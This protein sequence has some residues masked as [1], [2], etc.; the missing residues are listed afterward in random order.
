MIILFSVFD[1]IYTRKIEK[2]NTHEVV[3]NNYIGFVVIIIV[4][5]S[6]FLSIKS[7]SKVVELP[8]VK[9][10]IVGYFILVVLQ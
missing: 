9:S 10:L 7:P 6:L 5:R 4:P 3:N 8:S 2:Q 1:T